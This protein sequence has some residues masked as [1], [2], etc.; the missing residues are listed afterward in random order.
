MKRYLPAALRILVALASFAFLKPLNP[1]VIRQLDMIDRPQPVTAGLLAAVVLFAL[2]QFAKAFIGLRVLSGTA[3]PAVIVLHR[4]GLFKGLRMLWRERVAD[5]V[6]AMVQYG[7]WGTIIVLFS[8]RF[9]AVGTLDDWT[10]TILFTDQFRSMHS[11]MM[12]TIEAPPVVRLSLMTDDNNTVTYYHDL[13]VIARH[14]K[15]AGAKLVVAQQPL[16]FLSIV[17]RRK[18]EQMSLWNRSEQ[19]KNAKPERTSQYPRSRLDDDIA[20]IDSLGCVIMAYAPDD[21]RPYRLGRDSMIV[22]NSNQRS[23][24]KQISM[25]DR[26][27]S[28]LVSWFPM[29]VYPIGKRL[30]IETDVAVMVAKRYFGIADTVQPRMTSD[31]VVLGDLRIPVLPSGRAFAD[32]E[33]HAGQW[34]PVIAHHGDAASILETKVIDSLHYWTN[35]T[36]PKDTAPAPEG[37]TIGDLMELRHLFDGKIVVLNWTNMSDLNAQYPFGAVN[38]TDIIGSVVTGRFYERMPWLWW[39]VLLLSVVLVAVVVITT[40]ATVSFW[41]SFLWSAMVSAFGI[42][43]FFAYHRMFEFLYIDVAIL[44]SFLIFTLVKMSRT[45]NG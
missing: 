36:S 29:S 17:Y 27:F 12:D 3:S 43:V 41:L 28:R 32:R 30:F 21:V 7:T 5:R 8:Y 40:R 24:V 35:A 45:Q 9:A 4:D 6:R 1:F 10:E 2:A 11:S 23:G 20:L 14:L 33:L 25:Y 44:L 19:K 34:L 16:S 37:R 42:W 15:D 26:N 38:L 31:G 22:V 18:T 39:T 13:S